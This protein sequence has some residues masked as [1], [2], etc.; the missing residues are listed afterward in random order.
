MDILLICRN[1]EKY[2]NTLFPRVIDELKDFDYR[3]F[4][5]ENNSVDNTKNLLNQIKI[6]H[7]NVFVKM[8]NISIVRNRYVNICRARNK[9]L[10]FYRSH[11]DSNYKNLIMLDT[12]ILFNKNTILTLFKYKDLIKEG[13]IFLPF[14]KYILSNNYDN[15]GKIKEYYY[16]LLALNYGDY[17]MNL[18]SDKMTFDELKFKL[19]N[20]YKKIENGRISYSNK[21]I[22]NN[23]LEIESGSGGLMLLD[24][25]L[26]LKYGWHLVRYPRIR[27][28]KISSN[29]NCEHWDLCTKFRNHGKVI[30][31]RDAKAEWYRDKDL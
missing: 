12:N 27:N 17:F 30:L 15:N 11:L 21:I 14:T 24:R 20:E 28:M 4:I 18:N 2:F 22:S 8:E 16:D 9:M 23:I 7:K 26:L 1:N 25:D 3:L 5:Y 13:V 29:T 6:K 19:V 10:N 31:I